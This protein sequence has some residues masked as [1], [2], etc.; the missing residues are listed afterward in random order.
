MTAPTVTRSPDGSIILD[1]ATLDHWCE[2]V[3]VL[4]QDTVLRVRLANACRSRD[5]RLLAYVSFRLHETM[6]TT[7]QTILDDAETAN[8]AEQL[9]AAR[10]Q[11]EP[12]FYCPEDAASEIA[13]IQMCG[14]HLQAHDLA[15]FDRS[16]P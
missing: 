15:E 14:P 2:F 5:P 12:C 1:T 3:R 10:T 8:L 4:T 9:D 11:S 13:G 16:Q 7:F 6:A